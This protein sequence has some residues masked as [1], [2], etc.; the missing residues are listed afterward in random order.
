MTDDRRPQPRRRPARAWMDDAGP[1]RAGRAA[2]GRL[3][4]RR[5]AR[6][7]SSRSAAATCTARCASRRRT[8]PDARDDG[9]L[10]EWRIIEALDGTDVPHTAGH[11]G[12]RRPVGAR[13]HLLPDGLRRRLVADGACRR[14]WPAPFDTD[15]EARAGLAYQLVEGIALLSK[16]DW[17]AKG[18]AGP[19]PARRLP[20]APGRPLDRAS[21]SASRA[22]SSRASTRPRRGC[23]PTSRIDFI[24]GLMHGDYQFANVMYRH[25]APGPAGRASSTGRWA[26]SATRSSTSAG[27]CRRWPDDTDDARGRRHRATSTCTGMPTRDEVLAHYARGVGPPGRRHR[28]LRGPRQ[29]EA[30]HRARAGLPARRRRPEAATPS[31]RSCSSSWPAPP[32]WPR[33][34]DYR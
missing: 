27:S 28:L 8:A 20:R 26:P 19:R 31:A 22:A 18:L 1:A 32:S 9:I 30:R 10:R 12:V 15:L 5:H 33:P 3:H 23:A 29:V 24:P 13:P 4:L 34:R 11:R 25:G 17:Q 7:R 16:V 14:Q 6:T 2:R 21:S